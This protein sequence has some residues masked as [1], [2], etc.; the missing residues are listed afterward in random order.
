MSEPQTAISD[1][2]QPGER[3]QPSVSWDIG[4]AYD[5]FISLGVL[6]EPENSG[7]RAS[8]AAGV[9]SRLSPEERGFLEHV[10]RY[11]WLPLH[12][13]YA[14]PA[15]KD[16][17]SALWALREI[18]AAARPIAILNPYEMS[19][20]VYGVLNKVVEQRS[21]REQDLEI[22]VTYYKEKG[23]ARDGKR[24]EMFLDWLSRPDE[25]GD[26][27]LSALQ[28][29]YR[30]FFAEEEKRIAPVLQ[31]GLAAAQALAE[32]LPLSELLVELSQGVHFDKPFDVSEIILV[33]GYWN[34]PYV[35]FP[36]IGAD[37]QL[38]VF[39]VRPP[40]MSLIPGEQVPDALLL[41]LKA[42]ADPTRMKIL[43]YLSSESL[44]PSEIARRLR[45][46]PPTVIHHLTALRLAGLVHLTLDERGEKHYAARKEA[47]QS[48][49]THLMDFVDGPA[50]D[51]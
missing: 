24:V 26:L 28:S 12:W 25:F 4:T 17:A 23:Q 16:A 20:Q 8:W 38:L 9:R 40:D 10:L 14:L 48:S 44:T 46:R 6:H 29:Y 1:D 47:I 50:R 39:G 35:M 18:P 5:F 32:R 51:E 19:E 34:T 3:A 45:L 31:R 2:S 13:I 11:I 30:A 22:L 33:P 43:R 42:L 49:F 41:V 27:Y 37:K 15:G 36:K 7:L 21:W